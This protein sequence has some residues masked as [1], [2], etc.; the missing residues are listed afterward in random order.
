MKRVSIEIKGVSPLLMHRFPMEPIEAIEKKSPQEQAQLALYEQDGIPYIPGV[1]LQRAL[2]QGA[3][4]SK[5]KGRG[6]LQK[7]VAAGVL[8]EEAQLPLPTKH[9]ELDARPVTIPATK[10]R[11]VRYRPRFD[12]W[13][14]AFT[15]S[16]DET[17]LTEDQ[18]RRVVDDT[19]S[20]VG[21]LDFRPEKKGPFGRFVVVRWGDGTQP[22]RK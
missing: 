16:Y 7:N 19:G 9:W 1:A 18:L 6:T 10:G 12:T 8:L 11:I 21:V 22:A 15:V 4:F 5:G 14:V 20:R 13:Q 3:T 2:V 17:L